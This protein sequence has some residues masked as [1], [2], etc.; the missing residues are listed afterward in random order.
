MS[1]LFDFSGLTD[2]IAVIV[3]LAGTCMNLKKGICEYPINLWL[4]NDEYFGATTLMLGM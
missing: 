3:V 1:G 4:R 2:L